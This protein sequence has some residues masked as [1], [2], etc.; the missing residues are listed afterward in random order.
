MSNLKT[1][2]REYCYLV[3]DSNQW[4]WNDLYISL[5]YINYNIGKNKWS[6][7]STSLENYQSIFPEFCYCMVL[8]AWHCK[9]CYNFAQRITGNITFVKTQDTF[10]DHSKQ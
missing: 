3:G 2:N 1:S 8:K 7:N 9:T 4:C 6:S 10:G 5:K